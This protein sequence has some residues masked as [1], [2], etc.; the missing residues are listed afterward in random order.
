MDTP[1]N[2]TD[3]NGNLINRENYSQYKS[4][5]EGLDLSQ[6]AFFKFVVE[7]FLPAQEAANVSVLPEPESP[8]EG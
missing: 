1:E 6:E 4:W 2:Y 5:L 8:Q 7:E 3:E